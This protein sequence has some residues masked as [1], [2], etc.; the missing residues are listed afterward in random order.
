MC[1]DKGTYIR[2]SRLPTKLREESGMRGGCKDSGAQRGGGWPAAH[3]LRYIGG[4]KF[5]MRIPRS[6]LGLRARIYISMRGPTR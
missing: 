3:F 1:L 4:C 2:N 6:V 5:H